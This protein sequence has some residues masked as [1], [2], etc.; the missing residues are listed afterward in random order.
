VDPT[1]FNIFKFQ[2]IKGNPETALTDP[3]SIVMTQE[4]AEK[5][6]GNENPLAFPAS[7]FSNHNGRGY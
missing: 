7:I 1:F 4:V 5:Y 2:F 3:N 6:F